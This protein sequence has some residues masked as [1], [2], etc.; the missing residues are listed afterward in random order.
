MRDSLLEHRGELAARGR[1]DRLIRTVSAFGLHLATMDVREHADAHHH[2]L[3]QMFD[4]LG[5][6]SWRSAAL[7]RDHR[8]AVIRKELAGRRPLSP[9]LPELDAAATATLDVFVTIRDALDYFG[10]EVCES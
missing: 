4:R 3:A 2:V 5:E 8:L 1:L 6:R 7:P 10:S 9:P